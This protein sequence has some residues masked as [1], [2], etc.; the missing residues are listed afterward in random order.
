M[1]MNANLSCVYTLYM[2]MKNLGWQWK[3]TERKPGQ[4]AILIFER[5]VTGP[6]VETFTGT[7][8]DVTAYLEGIQMSGGSDREQGRVG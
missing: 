3:R 2:D 8:D 1:D 6:K 5:T 7:V 4:K